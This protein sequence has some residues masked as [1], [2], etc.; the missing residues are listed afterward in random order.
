MCEAH[1]QGTLCGTWRCANRNAGDR[2]KTLSL[3]PM[4]RPNTVVAFSGQRVAGLATLPAMR[5]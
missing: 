2:M 3:S 4:F 5:H 1:L